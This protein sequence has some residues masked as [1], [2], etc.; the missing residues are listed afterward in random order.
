MEPLDGGT[1]SNELV[2]VIPV[3]AALATVPA[4]IA[5]L[6]AISALGCLRVATF[7]SYEA[8]YDAP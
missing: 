6:P 1:V 4:P 5:L 7:V 8:Q 2:V 3:A